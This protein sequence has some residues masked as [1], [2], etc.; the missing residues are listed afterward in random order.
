MSQNTRVSLVDNETQTSNNESNHFK[1]I[2]V[3]KCGKFH[4]F[5]VIFEKEYKIQFRCGKIKLSEWNGLDD[6]C[7]KCCECEKIINIENDF[8]EKDE[9]GT[10]YFCLTCADKL[11]EKENNLIKLSNIFKKENSD[12]FQNKIN[13][14]LE[15]FIS[16]NIKETDKEFYK[17]NYAQIEL[18]GEFINYLCCFRN[19]Y[20]DKSKRY[21]FVS[22]FLEYFEYLIDV[23]SNNLEIYDIYHFN[24]ECNIYG[25]SIKEENKFLSE[26]FKL[27]FNALLMKCEKK[28]YLSL[29][30][31][32]FIHKK[33]LEMGL[34]NS[35][36]TSLMDEIYFKEN[37]LNINKTVFLH[38]AGPHDKYM[39]YSLI[40]SELEQNLKLN[41]LKNEITKLKNELQLDKYFNSYL[42]VP[43]QFSFIRKS[44]SIIL[45]KIIK[46][47]SEKLKFMKPSKKIISLTFELIS[48]IKR[49]LEKNKEKD[50][51]KKINKKLDNLNNTLNKYDNFIKNKDSKEILKYLKFPIIN[52]DKTEKKYI[53]M[54]LEKES[55]NIKYK[56]ISVCDEDDAEL[57]FIINY[58]FELKDFT[59]ETIHINN[60]KNAKFYSFSKV[61]EN[62]P[63]PNSDDNIKEAMEKIKKIADMTPKYGEVTYEKLID[64][65]FNSEKKNNIINMND[66]VDYLLKF[67]DLKLETLEER[68]EKYFEF[69]DKIN[70]YLYKI[71]NI[72]DKIVSE[73]EDEEKYAKFINK[74]EIKINNKAIF[75]YLD[76]LVEYAMPKFGKK[77]SNKL[78]KIDFDERKKKYMD[79]EKELRK[80]IKSLFEKDQKFINY[81]PIYIWN[82][83]IKY[84]KDDNADFKQ[85][86]KKLKK[87]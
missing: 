69:N 13:K 77:N 73:N 67:L 45:N 21:K 85:K 33:Y 14:K 29:E 16:R 53:E 7:K 42:N 43:G 17:N 44:T 1:H 61:L 63:K 4:K 18:L 66:K 39:E 71:S 56:G 40:F 5:S 34:V 23:S 22:N 25:Y 52:L 58:L 35:L 79:K 31:L 65:Y 28:K 26:Q 55:E 87:I 50:I 32:K 46:K 8:Y 86:K 27:E 47:N 10:I 72:V 62:S 6:F 70:Q 49:K 3:C 9:D 11:E 64:F 15:N 83:V 36:E 80:G 48:R 51:V 81:I 54:E 68:N 84:I 75:D 30:M 76:N 82:K 2:L 57:Q 24:K 78:I 20:N 41:K 74:Y 60:K 12:D 38:A 59:S 19:L 37:K